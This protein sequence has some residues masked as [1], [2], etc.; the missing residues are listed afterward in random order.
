MEIEADAVTIFGTIRVMWRRKEEFSF[1]FAHDGYPN[2]P[3]EIIR[4]S[5]QQLVRD[6]ALNQS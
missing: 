3:L 6:R 2:L 5:D 1:V 4:Y